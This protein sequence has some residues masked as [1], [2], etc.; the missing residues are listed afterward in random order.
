MW[1]NGVR[2]PQFQYLNVWVTGMGGSES[3]GAPGFFPVLVELGISGDRERLPLITN[4][5]VRS[6]ELQLSF[7]K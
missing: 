6:R 1:G 2:S 5:S 7:L 3:V 4:I